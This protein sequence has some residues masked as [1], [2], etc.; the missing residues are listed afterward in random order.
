[1]K[2]PKSYKQISTKQYQKI[3]PYLKDIGTD[4]W[5]QIISIL[6]NVS[7]DYVEDINLKDLKKHVKQ[8]SFLLTNNYQ[9][10]YKYV[11]IKGSLYKAINEA[12]KLNTAQYISIKTFLQS[13][14]MVDQLHNLAACSYKKLTLRGWKYKG[15]NHEMLA[16]AFLDKPAHKT[17]PMV[18]FCSKV[19]RYWME[20]TEGYLNSQIV[21]QGRMAEINQLILDE[22]FLITGDG[23]PQ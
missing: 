5:V 14:E 11:W 13:G 19:L 3:Y 15:D 20:S 1:M 9:L 4:S 17:L 23:T 10:V 2:L 12:D 16:N 7:T 22:S 8:L 6:G 18:F 21:I